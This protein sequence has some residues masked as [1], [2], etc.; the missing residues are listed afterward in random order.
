MYKNKVIS[1]SAEIVAARREDG[2]KMT[3]SIG[4]LASYKLT[5]CCNRSTSL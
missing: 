5:F 4:E 3:G 2:K 1:I